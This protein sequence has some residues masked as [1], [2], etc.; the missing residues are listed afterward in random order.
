MAS[1]RRSLGARLASWLRMT[2][3]I[4]QGGAIVVRR[5]GRSTQIVV[6]STRR[7]RNRWVLPKGSVEPGERARD[8]ALREAREEAGVTGKVRER[9]GTAEYN[10]RSGRLRIEYFLIEFR[11]EVDSDCEGRRVRWCSVED[12]MQMLT[13]ASARRV[14]LEAQ[15]KIA[16]LARPSTR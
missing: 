5:N 10:A 8:A 15:T 9:A 6:V 2:E 7:Y 16:R 11:R 14:L 3:P 13:Y 1:K 4:L 12:A